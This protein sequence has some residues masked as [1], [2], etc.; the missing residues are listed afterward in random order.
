[1]VYF[2]LERHHV[3]VFLLVHGAR[4]PDSVHTALRT[5]G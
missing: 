4:D 1:V 3:V 2:R 5:R